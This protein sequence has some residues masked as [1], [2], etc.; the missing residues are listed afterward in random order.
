MDNFPELGPRNNV[1]F[2]YLFSLSN[3][4]PRRRAARYQIEK[5]INIV[6]S[7]GESTQTPQPP[8]PSPE[9]EGVQGMRLLGS[10]FDITEHLLCFFFNPVRFPAW[11]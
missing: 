3:E 8:S 6:E 5:L 2:S 9:G 10:S 7:D 4:Q 1:S 11:P